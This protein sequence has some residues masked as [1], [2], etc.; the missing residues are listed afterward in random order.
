M[1][2]IASLSAGDGEIKEEGVEL[3]LLLPF[4]RF[5]EALQ[6]VNKDLLLLTCVL[7]SVATRCFAPRK[8]LHC[9]EL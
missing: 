9:A 4:C 8:L 1:L 5:F 7:I 3:V 2:S 6:L